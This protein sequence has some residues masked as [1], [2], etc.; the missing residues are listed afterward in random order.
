MHRVDENFNFDELYNYDFDYGFK[1]FF[2]RKYY[3]PK[4]LNSGLTWMTSYWWLSI[5]YSV[6]YMICVYT[7]QKLMKNREKFR[8]H[9]SLIAWNIALAI[10]SILGTIRFLPNFLTILYHKGFEHTICVFDYNFGVSGCWAWLFV[11]SKVAELI[12]TLFIILRKQKL[13]FLH[14]Y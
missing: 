12:D 14:W 4:Y 3:S 13:I 7:G 1:L 5:I 6:V 2:E 9:R 11:L 10:F 8:L